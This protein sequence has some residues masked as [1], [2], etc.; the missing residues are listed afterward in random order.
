MRPHNCVPGRT[1]AGP[2][3][4][5]RW[6]EKQTTQDSTPRI[7][8]YHPGSDRPQDHREEEFVQSRFWN[9]E[10]DRESKERDALLAEL[11]ERVTHLEARIAR[12]EKS[13]SQEQDEP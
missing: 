5:D 13:G 6:T 1:P 2:S 9:P 3:K 12:L 4:A 10:Q 8:P 7:E 11:R